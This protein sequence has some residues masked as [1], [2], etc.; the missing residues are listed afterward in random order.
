VWRLQS[1]EYKRILKLSH[2]NSQIYA[3][4]YLKSFSLSTLITAADDK[5]YFWDLHDARE[6]PTIMS[7]KAYSEGQSQSFATNSDNDEKAINFGGPRNPDNTAFVFDI[8]ESPLL[9][10]ISNGL[11]AAALS[12]GNTKINAIT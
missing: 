6:Q 2:E 5:V 3:C 1:N 7:F 12:D 4:E 9:T 11:I 10:G 8:K